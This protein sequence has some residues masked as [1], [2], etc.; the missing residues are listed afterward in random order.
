VTITS[1]RTRVLLAKPGLDG[2]NRGI[3]VVARALMD[4]GY[5]V[6][7]LGVRRTPDEIVRAAIQEDVHA[8][9]LS[10]LSGAHI[11][12]TQRIRHGLDAAGAGGI[13]LLLGGII[14]EDDHA[15]LRELGVTFIHGPG[16]PLDSVVASFDEMTRRRIGSGTTS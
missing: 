15:R 1:R 10:I 13:P 5:E 2:H 14:P 8:I 3:H 7:Y 16:T 6:V 9:G 11:E 12:L 4:A